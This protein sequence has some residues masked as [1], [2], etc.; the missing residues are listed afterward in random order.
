MGGIL[1]RQRELAKR[2]HRKKKMKVIKRKLTKANASEK[3]VL[4]SKIRRLTP[5]AE[6]IIANLGVEERK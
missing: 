4:A 1:Q 2:R 5:G 3:V 6:V